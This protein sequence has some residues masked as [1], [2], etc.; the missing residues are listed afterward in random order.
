MQFKSL[1]NLATDKRL[2][3]SLVTYKTT[4]RDPFPSKRIDPCSLAKIT[5]NLATMT[6]VIVSHIPLWNVHE[7]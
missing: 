5:I 4:C 2:Q 3:L 6:Y 7:A 1:H